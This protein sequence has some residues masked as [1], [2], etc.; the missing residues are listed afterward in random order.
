MAVLNGLH[1]VCSAAGGPAA[2]QNENSPDILNGIV[3]SETIASGA[4]TTHQASISFPDAYPVL[5]LVASANGWVSIAASPNSAADPRFFV[6][7]ETPLDLYVPVGS[8]VAFT[9]DA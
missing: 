8:K 9:V 5:H 2:F 3:W 6:L 7:A 4:T 1:V